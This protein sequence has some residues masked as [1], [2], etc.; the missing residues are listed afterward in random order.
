MLRLQSV[1]ELALGPAKR[2]YGDWLHKVLWRFHSER[3]EPRPRDEEREHLR[4]V[5]LESQAAHGWDDVDFLPYFAS[6]ER[7]ITPYLDWLVERE[8][9][10][11]FWLE[12]E[13]EVTAS[14]A[15]WDGVLMHGVIDRLDRVAHTP[16][17]LE[18]IDYKTGSAQALRQSLRR[19]TE[20]TQLA[21]YAALVHAQAPDEVLQAA[22]LPL[23]EGHRLQA[24]AHPD[25]A[26]SAQ[27]LL[28]GV[29]HD[30]ARLR[31]GAPLWPLG[32]GTACTHCQARGLCRR[33]HWVMPVAVPVSLE[34]CL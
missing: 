24:I 7:L 33:D 32:Q 15:A 16:S 27:R 28:E 21:F 14:P 1:D 4:Q 8:A 9:Q 22:Y 30:L 11:L 34:D 2:D 5:A 17:T 23:D 29:G 6:F 31:Q 13:R 19:P 26:G 3:V 12:G 10:G 20:E 18:L 25:L